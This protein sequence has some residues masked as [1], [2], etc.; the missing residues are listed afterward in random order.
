MLKGYIPVGI[1]LALAFGFALVVIVFSSLIGKKEKTKEKLMPYECG[2]D[3][4]GDAH[5]KFSIKFYLMA[6]IFV[7][8][9]IEVVFLYPWA[10]V[11]KDLGIFGYIEMMVFIGI[12]FL[13]FIYIWKRRGFEWD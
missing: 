3:P 13:G 7:I 2:I 1:F 12:L 5:I 11:F 9:D 10:V 8:F 4:I 6:M